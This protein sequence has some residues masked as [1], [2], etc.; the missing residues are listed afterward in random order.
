MASR[1]IYHVLPSLSGWQV[2]RG[3]GDKASSR[4]PRKTQALRAAGDLARSHPLAQV[5][6]HNADGRIVTDRLYDRAAFRKKAKAKLTVKKG[7]ATRERKRR[8]AQRA[9]L[10][11]RDAAQLG[12]ARRRRQQLKRSAAARKAAR[13][14]RS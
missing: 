14:R 2:K 11:R 12:L 4:H 10:K 5:V 3:S 7:R 6:V 8:Q 9:R 13:S 1:I